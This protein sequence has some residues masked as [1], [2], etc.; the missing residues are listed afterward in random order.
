MDEGTARGHQPLPDDD[1]MDFHEMVAAS[2][3]SL[4]TQTHQ[5]YENAG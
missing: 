1:V 5:I 4:K 3:K 2:V